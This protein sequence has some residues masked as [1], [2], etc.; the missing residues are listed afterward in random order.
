MSCG[1][2]GANS[3]PCD[4]KSKSQNEKIVFLTDVLK[5]SADRINIIHS[6]NET[7]K[8]NLISLKANSNIELTDNERDFLEN[9]PINVNTEDNIIKFANKL[10]KDYYDKNLSEVSWKDNF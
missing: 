1:C 7:I 2:G 3:G 5:F 9:C 10:L 8:N 4:G 6:S